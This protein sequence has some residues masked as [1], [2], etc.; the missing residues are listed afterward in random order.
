MMLKVRR[1]L[2]YR[3]LGLTV[4]FVWRGRQAQDSGFAVRMKVPFAFQT[5]SGQHFAPGVYTIQ[6]R[7]AVH[8]DSRSGVSGWALTQVTMTACPQLKARRYSRITATSTSYAAW[9]LGRRP[10]GLCRHLESRNG[11]RN[12]RGQNH[13]GPQSRGGGAAGRTLKTDAVRKSIATALATSK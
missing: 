6:E 8:A 11:S 2:W 7:R 10:P 3:P 5:A 4:A 9:L 13:G 1:R 12:S